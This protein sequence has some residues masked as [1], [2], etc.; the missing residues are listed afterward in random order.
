[1]PMAIKVMAPTPQPSE[2]PK[3]CSEAN[4]P[5]CDPRGY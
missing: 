5:L 1:M 3:E 4:S 2:P